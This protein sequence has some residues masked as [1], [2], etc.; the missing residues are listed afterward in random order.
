MHGRKKKIDNRNWTFHLI[1]FIKYSKYQFKEESWLKIL[2]N[3]SLLFLETISNFKKFC[4][5]ISN[6]LHEYNYT[7]GL[8]R[9]S[10]NLTF[11]KCDYEFW[12]TSQ[13]SILCMYADLCMYEKNVVWFIVNLAS[14]LHLL[15]NRVIT[16]WR[17]LPPHLIMWLFMWR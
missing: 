4:I 14:L 8:I 12:K 13:L 3:L 9:F 10:K 7:I 6:F 17:F 15:V 5:N 1:I 16:S 2:I 11:P